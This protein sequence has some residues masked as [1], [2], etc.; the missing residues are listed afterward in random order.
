MQI[1]TNPY[2]TM[3]SGMAGPDIDTGP[4][5]GCSMLCPTT[6]AAQV[7]IATTTTQVRTPMATAITR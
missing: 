4:V 6:T 1:G 5:P 2:Q 7:P 3:V